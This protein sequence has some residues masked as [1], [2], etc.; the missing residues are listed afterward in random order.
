MKFLAFA[1]LLQA[2]EFFSLSRKDSILQIWSYENLKNDLQSGLP[3]PHFL[4][5]IIFADQNFKWLALV[6]IILAL[7][8]IF[9]S[10]LFIFIGVFIIHL[11]ICI[12]FR[13]T[14]NGG[15]DMMTFI[16]LTGVIINLSASNE[17]IQKLGIYYILIHTFYS[18]FKAGFVKILSSD[19]RSGQALPAFLERSLFP[20]VRSLGRLLQSKKILS[21]ILCWSTIIFE[22]GIVALLFYP[23]FFPAYFACALIFHL[24][25]YTSFGLNRFFWIWGA[26]G[27]ITFLSQI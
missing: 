8:G 10:H 26:A 4:V 14:F 3:L 6:Q 22:L 7:S 15:S 12:R 19:W 1:M 13:G 27:A 24:S 11:L 9:Y 5:K 21:L 18:Y 2:I 16:L 25:I 23:S 17:K 20:D